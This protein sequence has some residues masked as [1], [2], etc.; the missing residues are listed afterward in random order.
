MVGMM[1]TL[2]TVPTTKCNSSGMNNSSR[3]GDVQRAES[4]TLSC[5]NVEH[6]CTHLLLAII[7]LETAGECYAPM[8]TGDEIHD[9]ALSYWLCRPVAYSQLLHFAVTFAT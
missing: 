9:L 3:H 6:S 1:Q 5:E 2:D 7:N 8:T 4:S